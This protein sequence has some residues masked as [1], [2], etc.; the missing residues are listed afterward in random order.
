MTATYDGVRFTDADVV[1]PDDF[2]P[3]GGLQPPPR[4]PLGLP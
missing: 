1:N 3:R 2:I 4:P